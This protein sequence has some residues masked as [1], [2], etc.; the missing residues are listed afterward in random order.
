MVENTVR[1]VAVYCGSNFGEGDAYRI[2]AAELGTL[3]GRDGITL[4]Y[5]G[6]HK[7]LMGI[8][9]DAVLEAGGSAH[10]MITERLHAKG[11]LHPGLTTSEILPSMRERK[12]RMI[13]AADAFIALPGGIGTLEEFLE[14]WTLNQLGEITKPL[15][16]YNVEGYYDPFMQFIDS[17]IARKFLP[18]THRH[19][20]VVSGVPE[21]LVEGLRALEPITTAKW[22]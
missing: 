16:L 2:A 15:G 1:S 22:M 19:S 7:G 13:E 3:L 14:V 8:L 18:E 11:H 20:I 9:A 6:T 10:G 12:A 5:G 17:M 4:I 21:D